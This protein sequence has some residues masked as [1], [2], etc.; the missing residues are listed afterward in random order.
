MHFH[1][2]PEEGFYVLAG[3]LGLALDDQEVVC[4]A[5]T[6][7]AVAPGQRHLFWNPGSEPAAYLTPIAPGGFENYFRALASGLSDAR[8]HEEAA[9]LR[10]QLSDA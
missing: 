9:T 7:A 3:E 2:H 6:Y 4:G 8:S 10:Q 5:G 1:A